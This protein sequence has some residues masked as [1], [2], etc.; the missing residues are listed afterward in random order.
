MATLREINDAIDA[1]L[2]DT[3]Y[4]DDDTEAEIQAQL[5]ALNLKFDEK[6]ENIGFV[7]LQMKADVK[8]LDAEIQRLIARKNGI[9]K[10]GNWL[11]RYCIAEMLRA[12]I[13]SLKGKFLTIGRQA[14]PVSA[15]IP[16]HPD[17]QE[18]DISQIDGRFVEEVVTHKV[19][20]REAIEHYKNTGEVPEGFTFIENNEHLRIR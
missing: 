7:R 5:A 10:R 12:G 9:L 16:I 17:T 8:M 15:D 1:L 20:K 2:L 3:P 14:S 19:H 11:D 6:L 18:P 4:E 13:K